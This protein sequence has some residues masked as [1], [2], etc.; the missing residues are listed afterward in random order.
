MIIALIAIFSLTFGGGSS[1]SGGGII[2]TTHTINIVNGI[3]TV[4]AGKYQYYQITVPPSATNV[5]I[6]GTFAASGG[7][8]NDIIVLMMDSTSF[9][10][11]Q[12][13]HQV[14]VYYNS[15]QLTT[16]S[17]DVPLPSGAGTY[18][19]VYSNTFS[20]FTQKNVNT[21]ANLIYTA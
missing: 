1:S 13:G 17:F 9:T 15:G 16:S 7:S 3:A 8:G 20:T 4:N 2:P 19:L 12:N 6:Q 10:N 5:H 21:Q 18:Y 11:W 14:S